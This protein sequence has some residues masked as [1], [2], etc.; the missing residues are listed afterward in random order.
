MAKRPR[1]EDACQPVAGAR[2]SLTLPADTAVLIDGT[3]AMADIHVDEDAGIITDVIIKSDRTDGVKFWLIPGLIDTHVHVTATTADLAAL[4]RQPPSYVAIA[5][6]AELHA[7]AKRGFTAVRDAG[8][9]DCGMARAAS[10]GLL[11]VCPRL[12]RRWLP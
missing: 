6:I 10:E 8:G 12:A 4:A 5:A 11:G 7:A 1:H 9:A 2:T 3:W